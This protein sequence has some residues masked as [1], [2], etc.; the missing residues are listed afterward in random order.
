[1]TAVRERIDRR[2]RLDAVNTRVVLAFASLEQR[3]GRE[4]RSPRERIYPTGLRR[5]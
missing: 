5:P 1:M 2:A 3:G 4:V